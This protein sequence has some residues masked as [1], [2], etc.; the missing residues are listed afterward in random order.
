MP[1]IPSPSKKIDL[2]IGNSL[3]LSTFQPNPLYIKKILVDGWFLFKKVVFPTIALVLII[4]LITALFRLVYIGADWYIY[5]TNPVYLEILENLEDPA[6]IPTPEE[7]YIK[8][9]YQIITV[10]TLLGRWSIPFFSL[11]LLTVLTSGKIYGLITNEEGSPETWK[12]SLTFPFETPSRFFT[13]WGYLLVFPLLI[14]LGLILF[15]LPG[16]FI[17]ISWIFMIHSILADGHKGGRNALQGGRFYSRQNMRVLIILFFIG[18]FLPYVVGS[19]ISSQ[20]FPAIGFNDEN[21]YAMIDPASRSLGRI[22]LYYFVAHLFENLWLIGFPSLIGSAFYHI[23]EQKLGIYT[24][25]DV[26]QKKNIQKDQ[27]LHRQGKSSKVRV[28]KVNPNQ[29]FYHC[30]KCKEK[31]PLSA[32]KCS[33]CGILIDVKI[34]SLG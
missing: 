17:F 10:I 5:Q 7:N 18:I 14:T 3:N 16:I 11:L 31:L 15:I 22:Y 8:N 24:P 1:D 20:V 29:D 21:Y 32:R 30:P 6:F 19:L 33:K 25:K 4:S 28:V 13:V 23:R 2:D 27:K 26:S 12:E 34:H 9:Y